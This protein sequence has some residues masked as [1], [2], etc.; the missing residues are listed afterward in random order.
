MSAINELNAEFKRIDRNRR[1]I[2]EVVD[3]LKNWS[4]LKSGEA[5]HLLVD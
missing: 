1:T 2:L 4:R 5:L 3:A